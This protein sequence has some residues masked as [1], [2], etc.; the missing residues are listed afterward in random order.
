MGCS[1]LKKSYRDIL[2]Q[3]DPRLGFI[4]LHGSRE[5]LQ[6]R[7]EERQGHFMPAGLLDSQLEILEPPTRAI[8]IDVDQSPE[9][10]VSQILNQ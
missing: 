8:K 6:R 4:W 9:A 7:M 10:M 3:G 1:A 5:V 2:R